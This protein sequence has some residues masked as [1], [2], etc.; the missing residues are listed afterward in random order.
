MNRQPLTD[1]QQEILDYLVEA[2]HT[3][4]YPPTLRE[5]SSH[6]GIASTQ[7]IRRHID[8]LEKKGYLTRDSRAR[9]IQ[10]ADDLLHGNLSDRVAVVPLV[11]E[12]A[13]GQPILASE[14]VEDQIPICSDWLGVHQEHFLLRVRGESMAEAIQPGDLVL[15]ERQ[16]TAQVGEVVVAMVED[17]ATVKRFFPE[18]GR[19][20]L[21]S[22]N[23][24][25]DDIIVT[26]NLTLLGRVSALVRKYR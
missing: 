5:L 15:V 6:F 10:L 8:A 17:E 21:R 22:D 25:F 26:E 16:S 1:R 24:A 13:A 2:I 20:V 9:S 3:T 14:N 12:V 11:G 18:K 4:G 19:V 7:G 23:P